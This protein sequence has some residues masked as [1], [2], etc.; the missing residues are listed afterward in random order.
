MITE[1]TLKLSENQ[2]W[3]PVL[4]QNTISW[5][6]MLKKKN[7]IKHIPTRLGKKIYLIRSFQAT[8]KKLIIIHDLEK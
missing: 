1:G 4:L 8:L 5:Q 2:I 7:S 6:P 3:V